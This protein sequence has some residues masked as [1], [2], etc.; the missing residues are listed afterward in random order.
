M[1]DSEAS[2]TSSRTGKKS[3]SSSSSSDEEKNGT[4]K[5]LTPQP[6]RLKTPDSV[7]NRN[8]SESSRHS[9]N[10]HS[11]NSSSTSSDEE[12]NTSVKHNKEPPGEEI[13]KPELSHSRKT[14]RS[15][16]GQRT[17]DNE[18]KHSHRVDSP[19]VSIKSVSDVGENQVQRE[20]STSVKANENEEQS[21]EKTNLDSISDSKSFFSDHGD[22]HEEKASSNPH[23]GLPS[24]VNNT[25]VSEETLQPSNKDQLP[26]ISELHN[27]RQRNSPIN[28]NSEDVAKEAEKEESNSDPK[29]SK[30]SSGASKIRSI[31]T[32]Q[33]IVSKNVETEEADEQ[34]LLRT[35]SRSSRSSR[36]SSSTK[37]KSSLPSITSDLN[38]GKDRSETSENA[39]SESVTFLPPIVSNDNATEDTPEKSEI[40]IETVEKM[41]LESNGVPP[42][43]PSLQQLNSLPVDGPRSS[44]SSSQSSSST[45]SI[46][47]K[48]E[49]ET[50]EEHS[51]SNSSRSRKYSSSSEASSGSS[52][53]LPD[54]NVEEEK[55][56][57]PQPTI[58]PPRPPSTTSEVSVHSHVGELSSLKFG[59]NRRKRSLRPKTPSSLTDY[60]RKESQEGLAAAVIRSSRRSTIESIPLSTQTRLAG[61][62]VG[63]LAG[64]AF[65]EDKEQDQ[66]VPTRRLS[67]TV[68]QVL[69]GMHLP[70]HLKARHQAGIFLSSV[71]SRSIIEKMT[72]ERP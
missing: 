48:D 36:A 41:L 57:T 27:E 1:S 65:V 22:R 29:S 25:K 61:L 69:L 20:T 55:A 24:E 32:E 53:T 52:I 17:P 43:D 14:S 72:Y 63:N 45:S 60:A 47:D 50:S 4:P 21:F 23:Q 71:V 35:S 19:T 59:Q 11:S 58:L 46:S 8:T 38:V 56:E 30:P 44:S 49:N 64:D 31:S 40:T 6:Q 42:S 67:S 70:D 33:V 37:R 54:Y 2:R 18:E 34:K 10:T 26:L 66:V 39:A 62:E 3:R 16:G 5:E 51:I 12:E 7:R 68:R 15:S 28:N 13:A 9:G